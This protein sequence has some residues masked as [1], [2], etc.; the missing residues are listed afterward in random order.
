[1][2]QGG[3]GSHHCKLGV[4]L[5]PSKLEGPATQLTFL[6]IEVGTIS[7]QLRLPQDK[8]RRLGTLLESTMG[9]KALQLRDFQSLVGL[10]QHAAQVVRPGRSFV[11]R[12]HALLAGKE[13]ARG[14]QLIHLNR[15]ARA[16]IIWWRL[17]TEQWNGISMMWV[18]SC[19]SPE[20]RVVSDASGHWGCGVYCLPKWMTLQWTP[21]LQ[22]KSI[23]VKELIPVVFAAG[24]WGREWTGKVA[25]F[26]VDNQ[27]VV[28]VL[29]SG[30][31]KE[32]H[33]MH[34]LQ[35]LVWLASH[36]QFWFVTSHIAGKDNTL[37]DAISRNNSDLFLSQVSPST[38]LLPGV[39]PPALVDLLSHILPWMSAGWMKQFDIIMRQL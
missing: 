19:T 16:D 36:F 38:E 24:V 37:A 14:D 28:A 22:G 32:E 11:R 21:C 30:Y 27:A 4:P 10:L 5:E 25:E 39:P 13:S 35:V 9:R 15:D 34:L 8:L 17:F 12:L 26:V 20:V 23:Q 33:L 2:D 31:S 3:A 1:M 29:R 18:A 6:G 7:H